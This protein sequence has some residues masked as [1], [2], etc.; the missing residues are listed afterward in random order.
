MA[1]PSSLEATRYYG[2]QIENTKLNFR[3]LYLH[4]RYDQPNPNQEVV[5]K[6]SNPPA[7]FGKTAVNN[8]EIYEGTGPDAKLVA[9]AQ[10]MQ[11]NAGNWYNSFIM[12][13]QDER[14]VTFVY[15]CATFAYVGYI[16]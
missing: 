15:I 6:G 10:G 2:P 13:F 1:K 3:N 12:V 7:E 4:Q 8:W 9:R 14:Y 16:G 11:M 5:F